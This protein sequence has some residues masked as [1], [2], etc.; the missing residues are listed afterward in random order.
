MYPFPYLECPETMRFRLVGV[1]RRK[2][3]EDILRHSPLRVPLDFEGEVVR[4][5]DRH[6][7]VGGDD[8]WD[9]GGREP[10]QDNEG[11]GVGEDS[12]G[13]HS[14]S[15]ICGDIGGGEEFSVQLFAEEPGAAVEHSV[16]AEPW[17]FQKVPVKKRKENGIM[18]LRTSFK[19]VFHILLS[20][21]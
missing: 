3:E 21:I 7:V 8:V 13:Q 11:G 15:V 1:Q 6:L 2:H 17:V 10:V 16:A 12:E 5:E 4:R 19:T 14:D 18:I 20:N 9:D